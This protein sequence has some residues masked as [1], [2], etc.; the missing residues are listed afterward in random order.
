MI[1][2]DLSACHTL[3]ACSLVCFSS[4]S[5]CEIH[6]RCS[7]GSQVASAGQSVKRKNATTPSRMAG[8]PSRTNSHRQPSKA[9]HLW[10]RIQPA[11]GEP[12]T[13]DMGIAAM[14]LL[15]AF[16]RSLR[17]EQWLRYTIT[18]GKKP[19]SDEPNKNSAKV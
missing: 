19:D 9:N 11:I 2:G 10:P 6:R 8:S 15:V 1:V 16:A 5:S 7:G 4:C 12:M 3:I 14:K 13:N 17:L 18:P